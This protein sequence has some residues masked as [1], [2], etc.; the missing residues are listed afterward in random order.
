MSRATDVARDFR[1]PPVDLK[2]SSLRD[3][4]KIL[5]FNYAGVPWSLANLAGI[6]AEAGELSENDPAEAERF[7]GNRIVAGGG[8][9]MKQGRWEGAWAGAVASESA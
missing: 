2:W 3:R 6:E 9:W 5:E 1:T 4:R 7:F 8:A